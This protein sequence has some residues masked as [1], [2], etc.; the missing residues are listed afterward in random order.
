VSR[1]PSKAAAAPASLMRSNEDVPVFPGLDPVGDRFGRGLADLLASLGYGESV[2][3]ASAT[4]MTSVSEWQAGRS[5]SDALLRFQLKPIKGPMLISMPV[6]LVAQLVDMFFGGDG[7]VETPEHDLSP[8]EQRFLSRLGEQCLPLLTSAWKDVI[9]IQPQL[10]KIEPSGSKPALGKAQDLI[11]VQPFAIS[12]PN[13]KSEIQCIFPV[14][15]L[16]P[17]EALRAAPESETA[18]VVDAVWHDRLEQ[19]VMQVRLPIRSVFARPE[20]SLEKLI[21]LKPGDI[22]PVLMPRYVP[23]TIGDRLFAHGSVGESNGRTAI[24]IESLL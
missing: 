4:Q 8:A 12:G 7:L 10:V 23:V 16:R 9:S 17:I 22:I 6:K 18:P 14:S 13:G 2:I 11:A 5:A 3:R 15:A 19:A 24:K 21:A 20:L 1:A